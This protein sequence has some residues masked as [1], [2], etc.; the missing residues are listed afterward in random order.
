[1]FEKELNL[2]KKNIYVSQAIS[3]LSGKTGGFR[4]YLL[5]FERKYGDAPVKSSLRN[6]YRNS[7][8]E[9]VD[10]KI[11]VAVLIIKESKLI[12]RGA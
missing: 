3:R 9:I 6:L 7:T 12:K 8:K 4:E 5:Y 11:L 1:M 2:A 10:L